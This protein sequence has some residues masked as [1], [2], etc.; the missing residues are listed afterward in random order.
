MR[1]RER[2]RE[3]ETE[4]GSVIKRG[5]VLKLCRQLVSCVCSRVLCAHGEEYMY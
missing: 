2:A 1:E 5:S 3:R 4:R